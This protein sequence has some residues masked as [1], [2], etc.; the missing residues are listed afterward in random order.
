MCC[1]RLQG[2]PWRSR[3]EVSLE[4]QY[5]SSALIFS[6]YCKEGGSRFLHIKCTSYQTTQFQ[7]WHMDTVTTKIIITFL[8]L[9]LQHTKHCGFLASDEG[10]CPKFLSQLHSA[11]SH[12]FNVNSY[13]SLKCHRSSTEFPDQK[14]TFSLKKLHKIL[15]VHCMTFH[16][17]MIPAFTA[18]IM[19]V[20]LFLASVVQ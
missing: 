19:V 4:H 9:R 1:F 17:T 14:C 11:M 7:R 8:H 5:L 2:L 20:M 18:G 12:N 10:K 3:R 16:K 6:S 15:R 13:N